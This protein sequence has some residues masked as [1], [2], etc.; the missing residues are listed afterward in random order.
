MKVFVA[1][2]RKYFWSQD[3]YFVLRWML[4]ILPVVGLSV[5]AFYLLW[6]TPLAAYILDRLGLRT[7]FLPNMVCIGCNN[8]TYPYVIDNEHFCTDSSG[9]L[10]SVFLLILVASFHANLDARQA[11]RKSWGSLREYQGQIVRTLFIFGSHEDKNYNYQIQYEFKHYGDV[12]Q[13]DFVDGY[14]WLTN[15]TMAGLHWVRKFCPT[16]K[17]I[18][19]TDDDGFNVPQRFIDYLLGVGADQFIGGY[20]FTVMPDRRASSKFYVPHSM[21]PDQYYP[22]YCSGPGYV[23]SRSTAASILSVSADVAFLPMEDV[24]VTGACRV[25]AGISYTQVV[26]VVE[27]HGQMTR[28]GL[29][30][31]VKNGHNVYPQATPK[32]W[33][34]AV[35]ADSLMDCSARNR[36]VLLELLVLIAI[37]LKHLYLVVRLGF[38]RHV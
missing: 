14:R 21:Y 19:K 18:L 11:I 1:S 20:C 34:R 4:L 37:W 16:A 35:D 6:F 38:H 24:F 27:D 9:K 28:C 22:T 7:F 12:M 31:W 36:L 3:Q 5:G 29:A 10:Q 17:F 2:R 32:I 13:A 33:Q 8:F 15:K 30:T 26:G 25:V 23:L